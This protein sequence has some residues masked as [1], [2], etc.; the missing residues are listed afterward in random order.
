MKK[1]AI[2]N[3][4]QRSH[5][6]HIRSHTS[7]QRRLARLGAGTCT[8]VYY[9]LLPQDIR[10]VTSSFLSQSTR[11][12]LNKRPDTKAERITH[13]MGFAM[14]TPPGFLPFVPL[15]VSFLS[16][17][18]RSTALATERYGNVAVWRSFWRWPWFGPWCRRWRWRRWKLWRRLQQ[19]FHC[20]W[21]QHWSRRRRG[22]ASSCPGSGSCR[23]HLFAVG[24]FLRLFE[25]Y[26]MGQP[27]FCHCLSLPHQHG[28]RFH[29]TGLHDTREPL[30]L[31][32]QEMKRHSTLST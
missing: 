5:C 21:T 17:L 31:N 8:S 1:E 10:K 4:C 2:Q 24:C 29:L 25:T 23:L 11:T 27:W 26:S 19:V 15:S 18:V 12:W 9:I 32:K 28:V 7:T 30:C 22:A 16:Q 6:R 13:T 14:H 20:D 3:S